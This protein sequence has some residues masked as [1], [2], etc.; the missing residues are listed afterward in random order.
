VLL[1]ASQPLIVVETSVRVACLHLITSSSLFPAASSFPP[2]AVGALLGKP[3]G[4]STSRL[5][6][7][8][9]GKRLFSKALKV[10]LEVD[11][12]LEA[13][14]QVLPYSRALEPHFERPA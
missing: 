10:G 11:S 12:L 6:H 5:F 7:F 9:F 4:G 13:L 3:L 1:S 2:S 8:E 14:P